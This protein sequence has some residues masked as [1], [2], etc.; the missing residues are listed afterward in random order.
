MRRCARGVIDATR[1]RTANDGG[2]GGGGEEMT[3]SRKRPASPEAPRRLVQL[4]D[5]DGDDV[6]CV[7]YKKLLKEQ[8][9][10]T[11][12]RGG[13]DGVG[14]SAEKAEDPM[15]RRNEPGMKSPK[16][17]LESGAT[18]G[19]GHMAAVIR[20]IEAL[21]QGGRGNASSDEDEEEDEEENSEIDEDDEEEDE[22]EGESGDEDGEGDEEGESGD[23][24][25][26]GSEMEDPDDKPTMTPNGSQRIEAPST[27]KNSEEKK[28][29]PKKKKK[30]TKR[31]GDADWYDVDDDF[32]DDEELDEYFEDDGLKTKHSGFFINKGELQKVD[33]EGRTPVKVSEVEDHSA[34]KKVAKVSKKEKSVE[35]TEEA[36]KSLLKAVTKYGKKWALIQDCGEFEELKAYSTSRMRSQWTILH[37]ELKARGIDIVIPIA[38]PKP[39]T[40][41]KDVDDDEGDEGGLNTPKKSQP[42]GA[43]GVTSSQKKKA[44]AS[45]KMLDESDPRHPEARKKV[46]NGKLNEYAKIKAMVEAQCDAIRTANKDKVSGTRA[47]PYTF[48]W[49]DELAEFMYCT[50]ARI[51]FATPK[52]FSAPIWTE[53]QK[54]WPEDFKMDEA[55]LRK[56]HTQIQ[57]K[58]TTAEKQAIVGLVSE[59]SAAKED[60]PA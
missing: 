15:R 34:A 56:K 60:S 40:M 59:V 27:T 9:G 54:L 17:L 57:K 21:Y 41:A 16:S 4:L 10:N 58:K 32:I 2:I 48:E 19:G 29:K 53:V 3:P 35:W 20:R 51:F 36:K 30:K 26:S 6:P 22:A 50:L 12:S 25:D 11:Y 43:S 39:P 49:T 33:E 46:L 18:G 13:G 44:K 45:N 24:D 52:Q 1:V 28:E 5:I 37:D 42:M 8:G 47:D 14:S 23:E 7:N 31:K 55:M 38:P